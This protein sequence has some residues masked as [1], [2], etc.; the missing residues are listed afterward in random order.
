MLDKIF[1]LI[2]SYI[3]NK[4]FCLGVVMSVGIFSHYIFGAN[5]LAEEIS[6][7]IIH[8]TTNIEI[9]FTPHVPEIDELTSVGIR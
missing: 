2:R 5:N 3:L 6:E 9:D 4:S 8:N 1:P 7:S